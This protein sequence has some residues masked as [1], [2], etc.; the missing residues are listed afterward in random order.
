MEAS[1]AE[2]DSAIRKHSSP[3]KVTLCKLDS[4]TSADNISLQNTQFAQTQCFYNPLTDVDWQG[5]RDLKHHFKQRLAHRA[6][7][8]TQSKVFESEVIG[9]HY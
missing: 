1:M 9:L 4:S 3:S 5:G 7:Q 6:M 2:Q 8:Q